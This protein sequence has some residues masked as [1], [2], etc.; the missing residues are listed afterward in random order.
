MW[1]TTD[2]IPA[3]VF[4]LGQ[5]AP[6]R[7]CWE[8]LKNDQ[9]S[10]EES[11]FRLCWMSQDSESNLIDWNLHWSRERERDH[12]GHLKNSWV[13]KGHQAKKEEVCLMLSSTNQPI[14]PLQTFNKYKAL[15]FTKPSLSHFLSNNIENTNLQRKI[16]HPTPQP[17]CANQQLGRPLA[18]VVA[19]CC[20]RSKAQRISSQ[21]S[22]SSWSFWEVTNW[23]KPKKTST[24]TTRLNRWRRNEA[25]V[26]YQFYFENIEN[27][28]TIYQGD[29]GFFTTK[30]NFPLPCFRLLPTSILSAK[31]VQPRFAGG[32]TACFSLL[33]K[34][35][36][37]L[38]KQLQ[39][40]VYIYICTVY[41]FMYTSMYTSYIYI[42]YL[43]LWIYKYHGFLWSHLSMTQ[44]NSYYPRLQDLGC[45]KTLWLFVFWA[46][47]PILILSPQ[48]GFTNQIIIK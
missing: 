1:A 36:Y 38:Y 6:F 18:A 25:P 20:V 44:T 23:E 43:T 37:H 26:F 22:T 7:R 35:N 40:Y 41:T 4:R 28:R 13:Q 10:G 29:M 2:V 14:Y 34:R 8:E 15:T 24:S 45:T 46:T 3:C 9:S 47:I 39:A 31:T 33:L 11:H 42:Y 17:P 32:D 16:H 27:L 21:L 12:S 5:D 48:L 30:T 19:K